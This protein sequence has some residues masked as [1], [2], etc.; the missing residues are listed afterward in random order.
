MNEIYTKLVIDCLH[1]QI[2]LKGKRH[3]SGFC[4]ISQ[5]YVNRNSQK[6]MPVKMR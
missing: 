3:V 2:R 4:S 1:I 6:C 5:E